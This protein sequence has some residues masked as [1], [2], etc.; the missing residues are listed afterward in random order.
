MRG[1]AR[2]YDMS[3]HHRSAIIYK[4]NQLLRHFTPLSRSGR[5]IV[6][7]DGQQPILDRRTFGEFVL[8]LLQMGN[9]YLQEHR[10]ALGGPLGLQNTPAIHTRRGIEDGQYWWV[11]GHRQAHELEGRVVHLFEPELTQELY[12]MP[13]W[14]SALQAGLLNFDATIFRRKYYKNGSHMGFILYVGEANLS[15]EDADAIE[16]ALEDS[17][18]LGNFKNMFLHIPEGKEK[19]VQLIPIGEA[20]AKDEFLGIK[21]TSRDDILAAHRVP[22]VL[23]GVVPQVNGGFGKPAEA[24]DVFHFA[25]IEPLQ[26]RTLEINDTLGYEAIAYRSYERQ[27]A[28][29]NDRTDRE[30][31]A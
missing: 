8:N 20:A 16:D 22:P 14:S 11:P 9:A 28:P 7:G 12:G 5:P 15:D 3:P 18:G 13:E 4:R 23:I 1:L 17:K 10:N 6:P 29:A 30:A 21:N 26:M 2:A 31:A 24:A 25:E 19:G 27:A